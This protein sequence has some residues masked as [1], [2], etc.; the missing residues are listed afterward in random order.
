MAIYDFKEFLTIDDV[1]EYLTDRDIHDFNLSNERD[2]YR[3][4]KLL[5]EFVELDKLNPVFYFN[6]NSSIA[7]AKNEAD[8]SIRNI[9]KALEF[10]EK[11]IDSWRNNEPIHYC[12][13]EMDLWFKSKYREY[14]SDKYFH[15][16]SNNGSK[17]GIEPLFPKLQLDNIFNQKPKEAPQTFGNFFGTPSITITQP[18]IETLNQCIKERNNE[19][20]TLKTRIAELENQSNDRKHLLVFDKNNEFFAPDLAHAI[21]LWLDTYG[22]G[23]KK[24]DSHTNL[25]N[26]WIKSNTN[27]N[28][29]SDGYRQVENRIREITTPLKDFGAKRL[30]EK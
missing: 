6:G 18:S 24:D 25:A 8:R 14:G 20:A 30:K 19:I 22:N 11:M 3:L 7:N 13:Y 29:N 16:F 2:K 1:A 12:V 26:Q 28:E 27:Y 17:N 10:D 5:S 21:N 15:L 4:H 9:I 23:K